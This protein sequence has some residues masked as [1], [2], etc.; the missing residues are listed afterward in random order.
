VT[1]T[2]EPQDD[3]DLV[4]AARAPHLDHSLPELSPSSERLQPPRRRRMAVIGAVT[5]VA[6]VAFGVGLGV[7]ATSDTPIGILNP[8]PSRPPE[9]VPGRDGLTPASAPAA[10][11]LAGD[12]SAGAVDVRPD[13]ALL[14]ATCPASAWNLGLASPTRPGV[15]TLFVALAASAPQSCQGFS[16]PLPVLVTL[17]EPAAPAPA[18]PAPAA[19]A[20]GPRDAD[21]RDTGRQVTARTADNITVGIL[22]TPGLTLEKRAG[23]FVVTPI[24]P[25]SGPQAPLVSVEI[26][27]AG[28]GW[29]TICNSTS[30]DE[31]TT[32]ANA[33]GTSVQFRVVASIGTWHRPSAAVDDADLS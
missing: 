17:A 13:A 24:R 3:V 14:P 9:P 10:A 1:V 28:R 4:T 29:T 20:P 26:R 7:A 8:T 15:L 12:F 19:P 22:A 33:S 31:C 25:P 23:R 16:A 18:A 6:C 5:F 27:R 2:G 30:W 21:A 11:A 32:A